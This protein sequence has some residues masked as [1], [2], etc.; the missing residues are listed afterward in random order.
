MACTGSCTLDAGGCTT[1]CGNAD[2]E[3]GDILAEVGSAGGR[4]NLEPEVVQELI[5]NGPYS[6]AEALEAGLGR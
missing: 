3:P 4:E 1:T 6:T 5:D 2:V